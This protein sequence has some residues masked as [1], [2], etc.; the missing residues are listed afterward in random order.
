VQCYSEWKQ[1][2]HASGAGTCDTRFKMAMLE[3]TR[4]R[5]GDS[6]PV[7]KERNIRIRRG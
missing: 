4:A 2:G 5:L 7:L 3:C 1:V 6:S